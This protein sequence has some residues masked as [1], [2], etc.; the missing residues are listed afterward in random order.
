[1]ARWHFVFLNACECPFGLVEQTSRCRTE[2]AAWDAMYDTRVDERHARA[3][4]VHV[5]HVD[6]VRYG[7]EFYP[8]MLARCPH[9]VEAVA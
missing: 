4:G 8:L 9:N 7:R 1:M 5:V 2:E 3:R 6:H